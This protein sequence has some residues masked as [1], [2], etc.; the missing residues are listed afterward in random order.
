MP[1]R[2][3]FEKPFSIYNTMILSIQKT[4]GDAEEAARRR[5][6]IAFGPI[7]RIGTAKLT[8]RDVNIINDAIIN[9]QAAL[10]PA[11]EN[12]ANRFHETLVDAY[13][14]D[15]A[16]LMRVWDQ[17]NIIDELVADAVSIYN[18]QRVK[19]DTEREANAAMRAYLNKNRDGVDKRIDSIIRRAPVRGFNGDVQAVRVFLVL[20][21]EQGALFISRA[22]QGQFDSITK[23]LFTKAAANKADEFLMFFTL[24]EGEFPPLPASAQISELA[25]TIAK[26]ANEV[27]L[28]GFTPAMFEEV[29]ST[30]R[31]D[32]Y[33]AT[34]GGAG[35]AQIARDLGKDL[36]AKFGSKLPDEANNRLMLWARTEGAVVQNDALM[37]RG[38]D[39]GMNGKVW[40]TVGDNRVRPAHT[41]NEGAGVIPV[42]DTFPDGSTDGGSGSVSP[43]MCRCSV[44]PALL[45]SK[46]SSSAAPKETKRPTTTTPP[47]KP[48]TK[49][50]AC[51][52]THPKD[53]NIKRQNYRR[54]TASR[55]HRGYFR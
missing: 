51:T 27:T 19:T 20:F 4:T 2:G 28:K 21:A 43:F 41:S 36:R 14:Q 48:K 3:P 24:G 50:K 8:N 40:Q 6:A 29:R 38:K 42:G 32:L 54:R 15:L 53:I 25:D 7:Q 47:K 31:K 37:A 46:L 44:G 9:R 26:R 12:L 34:K 35:A 52:G 16:N 1:S 11:R 30:I 5:H 45:S 18:A 22:L 55:N 33:E 23:W 39:A 13:T 49:T 10:I 17:H